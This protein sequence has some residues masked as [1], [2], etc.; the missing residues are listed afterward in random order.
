MKY[1]TV[2]F[3]WDGTVVDSTYVIVDAIKKAS[4]ELGLEEPTTQKASWVIGLS[5]PKA[6]L[7]VVPGLDE[8]RLQ[9]FID[10]YRKYYFSADPDLKLFDG[11]LPMIQRLR[12]QG[13]MTAVATGKSRFGLDR[14]LANHGIANLF[15][16]TKTAD[17]T[18][19]KPSPV[20]LQ[21][22]FDELMVQPDECVMIGDTS[23]DILMAR[24][25]GCDSIAVT[26]GA[27]TL[28]EISQAEPS[29]IVNHVGELEHL[30]SRHTKKRSE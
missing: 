19:S 2:I 14:A 16:V 25:A 12:D 30:L 23:H 13:L 18:Q 3:D 4:R 29:Y 1:S 8:T 9:A 28:R 7:E 11:V 15:D 5:L 27:H 22:I 24:N 21:E 6:L 17:Q 26:Y 10:A 20:M